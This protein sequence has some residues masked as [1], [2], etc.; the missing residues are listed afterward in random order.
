V[1]FLQPG[2]VVDMQ[3]GVYN[4]DEGRFY[5]IGTPANP[6]TFMAMGGVVYM[7]SLNGASNGKGTLV[8]VS[9]DVVVN[10]FVF[11]GN[12]SGSADN[13][14]GIRMDVNYGTV[15]AK[16]LPYPYNLTVKNSG[17]LMKNMGILADD[18]S[19]S[20]LLSGQYGQTSAGIAYTNAPCTVSVDGSYFS[21]DGNGSG[22]SHPLYI[23][24]VDQ[25]TLT[26]S[27]VMGG[28]D[29]HLVK[30]RAFNT[31][32]END[33]LIDGP[34]A[35]SNSLIDIPVGG[36][37]TLKGSV[38][39]AGPYNYNGFINYSEE[40]WPPTL[41]NAGAALTITGNTVIDDYSAAN[42]GKPPLPFLWDDSLDTT[43]TAPLT[44]IP[45]GSTVALT[46]T[47]NQF[48]GPQWTMTNLIDQ[49][50][51]NGG[52]YG[53]APTHP[54][55]DPSNTIATSGAPA[56]NTTPPIA[57]P[58]SGTPTQTLDV[59]ANGFALP[60]GGTPAY[61]YPQGVLWWN[62]LPL[63]TAPFSVTAD[64]TTGATQTLSYQVPVVAG[65][66][67]YLGGLQT[68]PGCC[69]GLYPTTISAVAGSA[70][71]TVNFPNHRQ[72]T[73]HVF[74]IGWGPTT[75][76]GTTIP[77]N[78]QAPITV[79]DANTF[80]F[81]APSPA[82]S[83]GTA[84]TQVYTSGSNGVGL[85]LNVLT[86]AINGGTAYTLS[87][88]PPGL[89]MNFG[90]TN[91]AT[92]PVAGTAPPPP[93]GP[94]L[95]TPTTLT[96]TA[97]TSARIVLS[98]TDPNA[99]AAQLTYKV[100]T[101]PKHGVVKDGGVPAMSWTQADLAASRVAYVETGTVATTDSIGFSVSD[102]AG[103]SVSGTLPITVTAAAPPPPPTLSTPTA[104]KL[105]AGTSAPIVLSAT[106]PNATA[107][108]LTYKVTTAPK[109][110]TIKVSG[111]A[112]TTWT[113][114]TVA[115]G[116]VTYTASGTVATTDSIGFSVS[117]P[118]G[119]S[120]SGMLP[121]TVLAPAP[122]AP[123]AIIL[124]PGVTLIPHANGVWGWK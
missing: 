96:L 91:T 113:Q 93:V 13:E 41:N 105:V 90:G 50:N 71:I 94:T 84:S 80:T 3:A 40:D 12:P 15:D 47:G 24:R 81:Q 87:G 121:I 62:G 17:F 67:Q 43:K 16:G 70:T 29:G 7:P 72:Q 35:V 99:T 49:G 37:F 59:T 8:F 20:H 92:F 82:T 61:Y 122:V 104:L 23:D 39:E 108:Q 14:A 101:A 100:T 86:G 55:A 10:G 26:N 120:V 53:A 56:L 58:P 27:L 115:A 85:T 107:A 124:A 18:C 25:F 22:T 78:F 64:Q 6:V 1:P 97:G 28:F 103:N 44:H 73:G 48:F 114:A 69:M 9:S 110:G 118:A 88:P 2:D 36:N 75:V 32:I 102:P 76:G 98:A 111:V 65:A 106:D 11:G 38:L 52:S 42:P 119:N 45:A 66:Y 117:D 57:W 30:S 109:H 54:T 31:N 33:R 112:A 4:A 63:S 34:I 116:L 21:G 68:N 19:T 60:S 74:T 123:G 5:N 79:V 77:A 51:T 89:G 46:M 95:A 83:T